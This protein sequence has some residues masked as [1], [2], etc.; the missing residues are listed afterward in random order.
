LLTV[1]GRAK[2]SFQIAL[3]FS[4]GFTFGVSKLIV[5]TSGVYKLLDVRD[6]IVAAEYLDVVSEFSAVSGLIV[7]RV[8][9]STFND[10]SKCGIAHV[11]HLPLKECAIGF[12]F[13]CKR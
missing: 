12:S 7:K 3:H 5:H 10:S 6:S 1:L 13:F 8:F 11:V 9:V 2:S 4:D